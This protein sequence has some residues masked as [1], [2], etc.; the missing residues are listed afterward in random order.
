[1]MK[2]RASLRKAAIVIHRYVGLM[3]A[4]FLVVAGLTGSILAFNH[5]LDVALCPEL[6]E[7]SSSGDG[8]VRLH[9]LSLRERALAIIPKGAGISSVSLDT[10]EGE[11]VSFYLDLSRDL[12]HAGADTEY[13]FDPYTGALLGTRRWGDIRQGMKGVLPFIYDL[14]TSLSLGEVGELFLGLV[15]LLWTVDCFVGAYLTLPA[16]GPRHERKKGL[17][18]WF[19]RWRPSWLLRANRLFSFIFTWH[20]A[21]G[22]WIWA[23]LFVFAW[24]SV[25]LNLH[26]VYHPVM[27]VLAGE[28]TE[29]IL[30]QRNQPLNEPKLNFSEAYRRARLAMDE[31]SAAKGVEVQRERQ[32]R[33]RAPGGYYEYRVFS[34]RDV[35]TR[36]AN[37][38]VWIHGNTGELL[39]SYFPTGETANA[40]IT[41]WLYQLHFGMVQGWGMPYRIFVGVMGVTVAFLTLSGVVIWWRKRQ[42]RPTTRLSMRF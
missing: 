34:S 6:Y 19:L 36:Y 25:S 30:P 17:G 42:R 9:P 18:T 35:S 33:Y 15:A 3:M 13:F 11:A 14:H 23:M 27:R 24:S 26:E 1:M 41:T 37:T 7:V 39:G 32:F 4:V 28:E 38:S 5:E 10:P 29:F 40:T 12:K 16:A 21:S 22:L 20:R 31:V 2:R 8:R